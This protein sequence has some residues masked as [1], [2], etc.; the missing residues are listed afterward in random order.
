MP[1][2]EKAAP[3]WLPGSGYQI[4]SVSNPTQVSP[5]PATWNDALHGEC[6]EGRHG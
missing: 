2:Y 4:S 3:R 6:R 1:T 5:L